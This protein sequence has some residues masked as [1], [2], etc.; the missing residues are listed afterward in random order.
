VGGTE[1]YVVKAHNT[2][3]A[4]PKYRL[5]LIYFSL[6]LLYLSIEARYLPGG[7]AQAAPGCTFL[8]FLNNSIGYRKRK[9]LA[10]DLFEIRS[11]FAKT[12]TPLKV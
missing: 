3:S 1:G 2:V 7:K 4:G 5:Y 10:T 9:L 6:G 11:H 8:L 12:F